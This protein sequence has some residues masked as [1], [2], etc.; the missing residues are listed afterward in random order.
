M[1]RDIEK[2]A[3]GGYRWIKVANTGHTISHIKRYTK[4]VLRNVA[5]RC[6]K[7]DTARKGV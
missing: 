4:G 3:I 1:G 7:V 2:M 5:G 6:Q